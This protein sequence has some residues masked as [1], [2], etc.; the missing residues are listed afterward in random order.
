MATVVENVC[1]RSED[2]LAK[3]PE[4]ALIALEPM[5]LNVANG[6][7]NDF[8]GLVDDQLEDQNKHYRHASYRQYTMW[9]QGYLGAN[10]RKVIPSCIVLAI[11]GRYPSP[12]GT[13][14]GYKHNRL[15]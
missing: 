10:N 13:Y 4:F 3:S 15:V 5:V 11:R 14:V 1:C 2:C 9:R 8:L 7:R 6:Y 12:T